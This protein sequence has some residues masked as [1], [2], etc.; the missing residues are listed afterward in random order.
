MTKRWC[1]ER[2][3]DLDSHVLLSFAATCLGKKF[4]NARFLFL[5]ASDIAQSTS[6][7][8]PTC[9][10]YEIRCLFGTS[11]DQA[12]SI[13]GRGFCCVGC[14]H[15][16]FRKLYPAACNKGNYSIAG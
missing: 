2:S 13:I 9:D 5:C 12:S 11:G 3:S 6:L 8:E 4:S 15:R 14:L 16:Q 10:K 7:E 1:I